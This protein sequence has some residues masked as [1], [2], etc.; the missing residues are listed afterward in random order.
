MRP[1]IAVES[2]DTNPGTFSMLT[3]MLSMASLAETISSGDT[4][5]SS[6]GSTIPCLMNVATS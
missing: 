5:P 1:D 4:A 6:N 3:A 2:L